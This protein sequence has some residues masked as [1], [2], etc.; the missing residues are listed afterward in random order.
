MKATND[1]EKIDFQEPPTNLVD[2][3]LDTIEGF[4]YEQQIGTLAIA[5]SILLAIH[6]DREEALN[7]VLDGITEMVMNAK[8]E[9]E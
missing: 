6:E 7:V 2:R 1:A 3:V 5:L 4:A 9:K 8:V